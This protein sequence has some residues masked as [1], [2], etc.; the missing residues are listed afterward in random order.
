MSVPAVIE[1]IN[2]AMRAYSFAPASEPKLTNP[3]EVQDAIRGLK[4]DKA[5]GPDGIPIRALKHRPLSAVLVMLFNA[6]FRTQY[7]PATWKHARVFSILKPG[8]DRALP[9]SYRPVSLPDTIGE[10][11]EKFL[12]S[13]IFCEVSGRG[14]LCNERFGFRPKHSTSLQLGRLVERVSRNFDGKRMTGA[15]FLDVAKA[16]DTV[17][18]DDLL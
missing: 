15:V 4:V 3:A 16:F 18:T 13:R 5:L 6:I 14:L 2:E 17:W 1:K 11:F 7:Y 8:K 10:M 9:S 12:L